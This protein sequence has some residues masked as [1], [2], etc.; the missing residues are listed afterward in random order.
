MRLGAYKCEI[1]KGSLAQELYKC[2]LVEERHRHRYEVNHS[3]LKSLESKGFC[4]SGLNPG[5]GL[6]EIMEMNRRVHPFFIGTQAHPEFKSRLAS[7]SPM[8]VGLVKAA[9]ERKMANS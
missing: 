5:T 8:F 7:P 2:S 4:V 9:L 6:V 3:Y 1:T